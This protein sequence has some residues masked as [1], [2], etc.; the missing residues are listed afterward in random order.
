VIR[1][2]VLDAAARDDLRE[3]FYSIAERADVNTAKRYTS[4][5][6]AYLNRLDQ[7]PMR[8]RTRDDL[9][10]GLRIIGFERRVAIA[11][12]VRG[13]KV[14]ILRLLY[15]GQDLEAAFD[16]RRGGLHED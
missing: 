13:P 2:V 15:G 3:I 16:P 4:R 11:F 10:E 6:R 5:L 12:V 1:R 8:G 7:F 9:Y 14:L